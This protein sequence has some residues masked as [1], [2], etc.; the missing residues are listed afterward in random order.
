VGQSAQ[1]V[2]TRGPEAGRRISLKEPDVILG[3]DPRSS[4]VVDHPQVSRRHARIA[5]RDDVWVIHDLGSTNGTFVNGRVVDEVRPLVNGDT[6][7]LGE[8]V[9]ARYEYHRPPERDR[10]MPSPRRPE[11]IPEH[12]RRDPMPQVDATAVSRDAADHALS[13]ERPRRPEPARHDAPAGTTWIWIGA[14]FLVLLIIAIMALILILSYV[15]VLP[16]AP[17]GTFR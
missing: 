1:L 16:S 15:D 8:A 13:K 17:V 6:I 14:A 5:W 10:V 2:M 3:R 9:E 7:R 11:V 4:I 12:S